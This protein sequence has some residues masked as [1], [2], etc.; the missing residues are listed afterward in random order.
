[1]SSLDTS[2]TGSPKD[3]VVTA[4]EGARLPWLILIVGIVGLLLA[5]YIGSQV[6]GVLVG[7]LFPPNPPLP[8]NV[9]QV[10]HQ[11]T[12]HGVDEWVYASDVVAP[13]AII[14]YYE[15]AGADCETIPTANQQI[16]TCSGEKTFS[17]FAM[18]W[19]AVISA[20]AE[21]SEL[22]LSR[23]VF[24]TGAI[25]PRDFPLPESEELGDN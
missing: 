21:G 6:L 2:S 15:A 8:P 20:N 10:S 17:I 23:E 9:A 25:P 4:R 24:W 1:M 14:D 13:D 3:Q 19:D 7:I 22:R 5:L 11:S 18:R 12:E 16:T